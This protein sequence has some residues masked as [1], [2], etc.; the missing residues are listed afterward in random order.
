VKDKTFLQSK[1][2]DYVKK[3]KDL[4]NVNIVKQ[5]IAFN[6]NQ[7]IIKCLVKIVLFMDIIWSM[8]LMELQ[9]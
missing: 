4:D 1:L 8:I 2:M 5:V 6:V 9:L 3:F 7:I